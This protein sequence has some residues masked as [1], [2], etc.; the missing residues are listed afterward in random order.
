MAQMPEEGRKFG[1]VDSYWRDIMTEAVGRET[2]PVNWFVLLLKFLLAFPGAKAKILNKRFRIRKI[3]SDLPFWWIDFTPLSAFKQIKT[4]RES[5]S[6]W[7]VA[8]RECSLFLRLADRFILQNSIC[9][10]QF[11]WKRFIT[12]NRNAPYL[13]SSIILIFTDKRWRSFDMHES[14]KYAW[15]PCW[16]KSTS[17]RNPERTKCLLGEET[18]ILPKV[19]VVDIKFPKWFWENIRTP[20]LYVKLKYLS[21][22]ALKS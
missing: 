22:S 10:F 17:R 11:N 7:S 2:F 14:A 5:K 15:S 18:V 16:S 21:S 12:S 19:C 4:I 3:Q 13:L 20:L 6:N 8:F 9:Q 1:I